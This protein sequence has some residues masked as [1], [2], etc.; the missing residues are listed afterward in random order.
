MGILK[1]NKER[2]LIMGKKV[3]QQ[4]NM[5]QKLNLVI[6]SGK[7]KLGYKHALRSVRNGQTK[8]L[9]I[10]SNCPAIRRTELEYFAILGVPVSA[11]SRATTLNWALP[12]AECTECAFF[13]SRTPVTRTF[14]TTSPSERLDYEWRARA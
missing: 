7:Y 12:P 11:I 6:R 8:L 4:D 14:S 1:F 5:N 2:T 3:N 9:L 10:A 13:R